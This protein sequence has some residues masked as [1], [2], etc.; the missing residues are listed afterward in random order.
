VTLRDDLRTS[1]RSSANSE[2]SLTMYSGGA[3]VNNE[4]WYIAVIHA[5]E[6]KYMR[7]RPNDSNE[8]RFC[9]TK[10]DMDLWVTICHIRWEI[11]LNRSSH[12][13]D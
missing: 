9:L 2:T 8:T 10:D 1:S 3:G 4:V 13:V 6:A 11:G 7:K 12:F 5:K